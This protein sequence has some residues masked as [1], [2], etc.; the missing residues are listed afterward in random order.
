MLRL[1]K[2]HNY[3]STYEYIKMFKNENE[4]NNYFNN[5]EYEEIEKDY[6]IRTNTNKFTIDKSIEELEVEEFNYI[7]YSNE[8][9]IYYCF[10]NNLEYNS[11]FRTNIIFEVDVIQT[12]MFDFT[13][14]KS[15][16]ERKV[17][18]INEVSDFDEGLNIGEHILESEQII[19]NKDSEYFAMF[20][21]FKEQELI[22]NDKG[23]LISVADIPYATAKPQTIID[24]IL[25]PL[26]FMKLKDTSTYQHPLLDEIGISTGGSIVNGDA[27]SKKIYRFLKGYEAFSSESYLDSGGVPTIG[28]GITESNPYWSSL[29]PSCTEEKASKVLAETMYNNYALPL[30]RS[31]QNSGVDMA[32]VR[33]NHFDAFLSLCFNGGLGAVT[34]SPMYAKWVINQNDSTITEDW[35][36]WYIRDN[37]GDVLQGLIDRRKKE[38]DIFD[39]G[40]YYYKPILIYGTIDTVVDNNGHGFIPEELGGEL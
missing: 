29:F 7:S 9:K 17:C 26:Y 25:Y 27:I 31:M 20:N 18:S 39:N 24:G 11:Q 1:Y 37:N 19:F 16:I 12:F 8:G 2:N 36:T 4:Q 28:Y 38:S 35:A 21:G 40:N 15:F 13:I 34:S 5:L 33:Q 10:I 32:T 22:F 14:D 6:Y 23:K 3:D 30:Y